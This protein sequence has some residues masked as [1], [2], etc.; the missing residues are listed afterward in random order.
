MDSFNSTAEDHAPHQ[1]FSQMGGLALGNSA[2]AR[3]MLRKE[4]FAPVGRSTSSMLDG[5]Y[6]P[7]GDHSATLTQLLSQKS[8]QRSNEQKLAKMN[9]LDAGPDG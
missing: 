5:L 2:A 4:P 1:S 8:M 6:Q 3:K 7:A 9:F